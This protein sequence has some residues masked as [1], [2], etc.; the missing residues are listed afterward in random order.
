MLGGLS[1]AL[2][3]KFFVVDEAGQHCVARHLVN[4]HEEHGDHVGDH[5]D[6]LKN[7]GHE[8]LTIDGKTGVLRSVL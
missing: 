4:R 6:D 1:T 2:F 7:S 8:R 3:I 5:E